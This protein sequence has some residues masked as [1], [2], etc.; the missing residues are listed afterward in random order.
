[1]RSQ[2]VRLPPFHPNRP[3]LVRPVRLDP[4]GTDGPTRG[5]AKGRRWRRTSAGYYV[6][7]DVDPAVV[8][9][10]I[11]EAAAVIPTG[12]GA[13]TGWAS[14]RWLGGRWFDGSTPVPGT[15]RPVDLAMWNDVREQPGFAVCHEGINPAE[16]TTV[17]GLPVTIAARS[18]CFAMRYA[19][20][21]RAAVRVFD[22]AAFND[23]VSLEEAWT[24]ALAH[25]GWTGIPRCREGL[26]LGSENSW[27]PQE[28]SMRLVWVID[29]GLPSPM[30]NVPVFDRGGTHLG[31]PD[32]LDVEAGVVGE[33]DGALHL[34]GAQRRRDRRREEAFRDVGLEYFTMLA[35]DSTNRAAMAHRMRATRGRARWLDE[36]ERAWTVQ[37]PHWWIPTVTVEQRRN[38]SLAQR[39]HLLRHRAA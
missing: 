10:R 24:Y 8:E 4:T 14:L 13:V 19:P 29:A 1:M 15:Q 12:G 18:V 20:N 37:P 30:C 21:L 3:G 17:D 23:L 35:G 25:P 27:S 9:Q 22:M 34:E 5:Q 31:T 7:S 2:H 38:L 32:L 26:A 6:P 16:V 33:Y 28:S 39:S 11:V 36:P